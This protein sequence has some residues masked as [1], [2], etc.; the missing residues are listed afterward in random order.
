MASIKIITSDNKEYT[1]KFSIKSEKLDLN[2]SNN[3]Y[4][5]LIE[6]HLYMMNYAN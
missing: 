6:L 1:I 4:L 5:Y 3:S 2:I